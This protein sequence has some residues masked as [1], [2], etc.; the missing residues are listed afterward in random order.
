MV[1]PSLLYRCR[2]LVDYFRLALLRHGHQR[3]SVTAVPQPLTDSLRRLVMTF[4]TSNSTAGVTWFLVAYFFYIDGSIPFH[5]GNRDW[6]DMGADTTTLMIVFL[7][8]V[9]LI[10]F[11]FSSYTAGW[12]GGRPVGP[13]RRPD[14]IYATCLSVYMP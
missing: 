10:A 6:K 5:D 13:S 1:W 2:G 11:P 7:L 9:Q 12:P 3:Y 14:W 4:G 8:V